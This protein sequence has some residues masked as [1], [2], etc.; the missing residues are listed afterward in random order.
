MKAEV[1]VSFAMS[2][3][4]L[5]ANTE[6]ITPEAHPGPL[7]RSHW[8]LKLQKTSFPSTSTK[9]PW[10]MC[11]NGSESAEILSLTSLFNYKRNGHQSS[12]RHATRSPS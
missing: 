7:S 10:L 1:P 12:S 2:L 3:V 5:G 9:S 11:P 4:L 8:V 6:W